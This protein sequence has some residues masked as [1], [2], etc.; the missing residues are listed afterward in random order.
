[1]LLLVSLLVLL[2]LS[3]MI[4]RNSYSIMAGWLVININVWRGQKR[5]MPER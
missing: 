2:L 5:V 3:P 1:M 4:T